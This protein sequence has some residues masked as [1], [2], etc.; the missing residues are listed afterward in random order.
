MIRMNRE[1]IMRIAGNGPFVAEE[2]RHIVKSTGRPVKIHRKSTALC[3]CGKSDTKPFCDGTHGRIGF[4]DAKSPDRV[5]RKL[6]SYVGKEIIIH[7]DR[8][9]CSHAGFCTEGLP[10]VFRMKE[11]PWI[12]PDA[13]SMEKIIA[14]IEKCP[15]GALSY[16][17]DGVKHDD[18]YSEKEV[19]I[20]EDGPY[21]VR[22]GIELLSE[23]KP[24]TVNH[25]ALC[26]CGHSMNKPFCS[27]EHW[28]EKFRDEGL[29]SE[30]MNR[31]CV[32]REVFDN[33]MDTITNLSETGRS[34]DS[35]MRTLE[36]F[37]DWKTILFRGAQLEP[38]PYNADIDVNMKTVIG[39]NARKPL[40]LSIPFYVS[41]MSF[42]AISRE[43]KIALAKGSTLV[44]TAMCSGEGG[45]LPESRSAAR[46]YIYELGTAPF[47]HNEEAIRMADAVELKIGQAVK[48][49]LGGHLPAH[50]ITEEIAKIRNLEEGEDSVSPGRF[51]GVDTISDLVEKVS[52]IREITGGV[53]VGI[54]IAAAHIEQDLDMALRAEPDFITIDCRGGATGS[55]PKF[56]KDNV[57]IPPIFAIR[58]ARKYLDQK[59]SPVTLC[60]T[61]GFRDS[62][63]IAK[64]LALGADAVALATASL[65]SVGCLQ[66][67]VCH[68]GL[69]PAGIATQDKN[70]RALFDEERA[71]HQFRNFYEGTKKELA[72]FARANGKTD[73]HDLG[74]EDVYTISNEVSMNTDIRHV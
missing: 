61:G 9:I 34:E 48:P 30:K 43:A 54:K 66:S 33:K 5:K 19:V 69:C 40:T 24:Q 55:A 13:E 57:G 42:G 70:L 22:G 38:M 56:L 37:P 65:I 51:H 8:G 60:V 39:R 15:S 10:E 31:A 68:T 50:K 4:D 73:I 36:S 58:R 27:G 2:L 26:R 16:S 35:S 32:E 49:G 47:S 21:H 11:E 72:V 74:M 62:S 45:M 29:I 14:T 67:R 63:D 7:D 1:A 41:H 53:P 46:K 23:E 12:V 44:D 25:Y 17:V 20:T 6:E 3:R 28:Y 71:L 52:R 18:F 59:G 64:A